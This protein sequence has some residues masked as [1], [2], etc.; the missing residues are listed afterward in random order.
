MCYGKGAD[1][2]LIWLGKS[3]CCFACSGKAEFLFKY[4]IKY[5]DFLILQ[6]SSL[7]P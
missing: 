6:S 3:C 1:F 7:W 4:E 2:K 5:I